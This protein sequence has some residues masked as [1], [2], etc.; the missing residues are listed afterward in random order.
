MK[1]GALQTV[2]KGVAK[3]GNNNDNTRLRLHFSEKSV[4]HAC[5]LDWRTARCLDIKYQT[6]GGV[7]EALRARITV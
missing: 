1:I 7:S 6:E 2:L 5:H 4:K 3:L